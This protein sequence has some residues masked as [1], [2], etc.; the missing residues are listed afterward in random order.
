MLIA[1]GVFATL[2]LVL[3]FGRGLWALLGRWSGWKDARKVPSTIRNLQAERDGLKAE[4]AM[5]ASKLDS[6]L[7]DMK[8]RLA[9]QMAEV[10]RNRNRLLDANGKMQIQSDEIVKLKGEIAKR[11]EKISAL[12]IQIEENV[13]AI[14]HAWAKTAEHESDAARFS[15][16][17][18]EAIS[19]VNIRED[20]I[21]NL[22]GEAKALREI[23]AAFLPGKD[24]VN[25]AHA[26]IGH[27]SQN[28]PLAITRSLLTEV[29][30]NVTVL[31]EPAINSFQARFNVNNPL[32]PVDAATQELTAAGFVNDEPAT[33]STSG[34]LEQG[35][36]NVLSLAERVRVLQKGMKK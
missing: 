14:S 32:M 34:R 18:K 20:R 3:L 27:N 2:F 28:N 13:K 17:H 29:A 36:S 12:N 6:T 26:G 21:R 24:I 19:A 1:L 9:E 15:G 7:A 22:E 4:K 25:E 16:M 8:L 5:M 30:E 10:S 31:P 11:D 35:I 23:V 33:F